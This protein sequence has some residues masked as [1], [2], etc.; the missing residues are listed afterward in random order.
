MSGTIPAGAIATRMLLLPLALAYIATGKRELSA[1]TPL[2]QKGG[3]EISA[4]LIG[5]LP[6][7]AAAV[8]TGGST[9][10][11]TVSVCTGQSSPASTRALRFAPHAV[12]YGGVTKLQEQHQDT[13]AIIIYKHIFEGGVTKLQYD[14][15]HEIYN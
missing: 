3:H 15:P 1:A 14:E 12:P 13:H 9:V 6:F 2:G 8:S 5:T 7:A 4:V 10:F 11:T